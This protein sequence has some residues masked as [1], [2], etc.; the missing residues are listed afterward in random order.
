M[1]LIYLFMFKKITF[2][3]IFT[4]LLVNITLGQDIPV[5][6]LDSLSKDT[7][8]LSISSDSLSNNT[9]TS[10]LNAAVNISPDSPDD[11]VEYDAKDSM[12]Y[13][14]KNKKVYL[15]GEDCYSK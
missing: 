6:S 9:N 4:L 7:I 3:S 14:I 12:D 15:Y 5:S 8:P 11:S 13:D 1:K 2:I 10:S